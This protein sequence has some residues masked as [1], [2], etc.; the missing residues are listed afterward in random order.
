MKTI[1]EQLY[2]GGIDEDVSSLPEL[3]GQEQARKEALAAY[4]KLREGLCD[5][6]KKLLEDF[7]TKDISSGAFSETR[8]FMQGFVMA[9]KLF[10][11]VYLR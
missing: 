9:S 7:I 3:E 2:C 1:L 10:A 5:E 4:E 8:A 11:E 6:L